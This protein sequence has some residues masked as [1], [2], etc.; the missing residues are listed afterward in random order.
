MARH[1]VSRNSCIGCHAGETATT[2]CVHIQSRRAGEP[3]KLSAFLTDMM[4]TKFKDPM[5]TLYWPSLPSEGV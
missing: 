5:L 3:A 2:D 1:L 4:F